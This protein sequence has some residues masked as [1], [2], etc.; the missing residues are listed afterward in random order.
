MDISRRTR[1]WALAALAT[2]GVT[3]LGALI[4]AQAM[5][6]TP[7]TAYVLTAAYAKKVGFPTTAIAAKTST[8][9]GEKNCGSS[10]ESA[11]AN[12]TTNS[13]IVSETL[14]CKTAAAA[15][16]AYQ[17]AKKQSKTD[18]SIK[19]PKSLGT[20]AFATAVQAPQY[21]VVWQRGTKVG[22][23][24]IDTNV[25]ASSTESSTTVP[26]TPL[27]A[28]QS[29]ILVAAAVAQNALYAK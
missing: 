3:T 12:S 29:R 26:A 1:P 17:Q 18:A 15:N 20:A 28:A 2:L 24:A 6:A 9:T 11:Y 19:L 14:I 13:G 4:P 27:T 25:S 23:T 7:A 5:A 10:A 22:V 16:A 8:N 21:T